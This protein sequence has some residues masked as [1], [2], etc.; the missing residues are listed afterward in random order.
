MAVGRVSIATFAFAFCLR[1]SSA[2]AHGENEP[3][4][5]GG[6]IRMP[7]T[8]HTEVVSAVD[9][10]TL[11]VY[12]LDVSNADATTRLSRVS[13][14]VRGETVT[15]DVECSTS[16]DHFKCQLPKGTALKNGELIVTA[17]RLGAQGTPAMYTLPLGFGHAAH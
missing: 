12:L 14:E 10:S 1:A 11:V 2:L 6:S 7:E 17:K 16:D 13:V 4:P 9:G 5:H 3:G 8:F 15:G